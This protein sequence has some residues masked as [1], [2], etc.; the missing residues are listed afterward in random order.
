MHSI[1]SLEEL[2]PNI[3]VAAIRDFQT[4]DQHIQAAIDKMSS[5]KRNFDV[6][7]LGSL[8]SYRNKLSVSE[9]GILQWHNCTVIPDDLHGTLL[10][11]CHDHPSSGH[12]AVDRTWSRL[13]EHYF[14]PNAKQDVIN[15]V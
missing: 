14:W 8:K 11:L 1:N 10:K 4:K 6:C 9:D 7:H 3:T 15:W 2:Q 13:C 5:D 12:F